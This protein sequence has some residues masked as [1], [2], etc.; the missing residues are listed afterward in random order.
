MA[1][2]AF[3]GHHI[4]AESIGCGEEPV[5][6]HPWSYRKHVEHLALEADSADL[7]KWGYLVNRSTGSGPILELHPR[8]IHC[9]FAVMVMI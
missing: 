7:S 8:S 5:A 9:N 3:E 6:G 4:F 2:S 1:A